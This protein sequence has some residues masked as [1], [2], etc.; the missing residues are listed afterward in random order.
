MVVV[1]FGNDDLSVMCSFFW[2]SCNWEGV[3]IVSAS[4]SLLVMQ[5][6]GVWEG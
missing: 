3:M 5:W 6:G 2:W 4:R 1:V